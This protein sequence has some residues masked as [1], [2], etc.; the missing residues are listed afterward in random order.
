MC[1]FTSL[2]GNVHRRIEQNRIAALERLQESRRRREEETSRM[3]QE[4]KL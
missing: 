4:Y 3:M 2:Y 1:D